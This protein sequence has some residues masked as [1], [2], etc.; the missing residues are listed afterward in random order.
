VYAPQTGQA[1][2][3]RVDTVRIFARDTLHVV[4]R[5]TVRIVVHDT[6]RVASTAS[7]GPSGKAKRTLK[8][9]PGQ[10]PPAGQCRVWI[11]GMRPGQRRRRAPWQRRGDIPAG[12]FVLFSGEAYDFDYDWL[13]EEKSGNV[14]PQII[15]LKRKAAGG[16]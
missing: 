14:P 13:S 4:T 10:F 2:P 7:A 11:D 6:V 9:P 16:G 3:P 12:A 1:A 5:D 8:V 15:A